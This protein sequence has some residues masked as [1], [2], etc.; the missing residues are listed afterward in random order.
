MERRVAL[1]SLLLT[2]VSLLSVASDAR[3]EAEMSVSI[4]RPLVVALD[5]LSPAQQELLE[6]LLD[7]ARREPMDGLRRGQLGMA[8]ETN[9]YPRAALTSYCQ[10]EELDGQEPKW[11]YYQAFLLAG[12]GELQRALDALDRSLRLD[13]EHVSSWMWKG[14]WLIELGLVRQADDAFS[15]AKGLGLGWAATAGHARVLL[16]QDRSDEAIAILE[17]LSDESPFPSVFQLLGR[18]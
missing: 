6:D 12:R 16:H 17:P 15:E 1:S 10:A 13:A 18:A 8:Y 4:E 7:K 2:L 3:C 9:G 11:P 5:R 14:T